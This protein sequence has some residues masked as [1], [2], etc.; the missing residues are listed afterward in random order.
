MVWLKRLLF[1]SWTRRIMA[2]VDGQLELI[3]EAGPAGSFVDFC[4]MPAGKRMLRL[5]SYLEKRSRRAD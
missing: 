2:R 4:K 3:Y 5:S 1:G